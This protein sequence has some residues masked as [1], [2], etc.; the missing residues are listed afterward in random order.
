MGL[1]FIG[2]FKTEE[3]EFEM[4]EEKKVAQMV[5]YWNQAIFLKQGS[6]S[7]RKLPDSLSSLGLFEVDA[8]AFKTSQALV[9]QKRENPAVGAYTTES[10]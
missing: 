10:S 1:L 4:Q 5:S 6:L 3:P 7:A 9:L 2:D 8:S